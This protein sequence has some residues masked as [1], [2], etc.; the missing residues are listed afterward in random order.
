M[1]PAINDAFL[2]DFTETEIPSKDFAL[3]ISNA[4]INGVVE[5]LEQVK[6]SIYFILNTERYEH[7]IYSWD[8]GV[9]FADLVG[10]PHSYVIPEV[11]RRVTEALLQDDRISAVSDFVF[12]KE[13]KKLHVTFVVSTIFG[14]VE[15][16]VT[17]NV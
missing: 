9:E 6:Q 5:E 8:Y 7:L 13:K 1:I 12:E 14:D 16:E 10:Q 15:S 11:E 2:Q 3:D 4:K 17:V